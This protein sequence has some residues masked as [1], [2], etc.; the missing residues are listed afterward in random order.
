MG[1]RG[2]GGEADLPH[3]IDHH[4]NRSR[5]FEESLDRRLGLF[6]LG[7]GDLAFVDQHPEASHVKVRRED[8]DAFVEFVTRGQSGFDVAL[9]EAECLEHAQEVP[10]HEAGAALLR[11]PRRVLDVE[12]LQRRDEG[13]HHASDHVVRLHHRHAAT[14]PQQPHRLAQ[15]ATRPPQMLQQEAHRHEVEGGGG[16]AW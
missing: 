16:Q 2:Q 15:D 1:A 10:P 3:H 13:V 5:V 7:H 8:G 14:R 12:G 6:V 4:C 9:G 11:L